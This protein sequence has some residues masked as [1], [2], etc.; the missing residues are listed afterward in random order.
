MIGGIGRAEKGGGFNE[1][2]EKYD[3][4][5]LRVLENGEEFGVG[6]LWEL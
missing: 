1:A 6:F 2:L 5:K 4:H 3:R